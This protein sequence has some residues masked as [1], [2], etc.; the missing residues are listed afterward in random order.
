MTLLSCNV[1]DVPTWDT[2]PIQSLDPGML[3]LVMRIDGIR[4]VSTSLFFKLKYL[5][6][7]R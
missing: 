3:G 6:S 2:A 7:M 5:M 4:D 1:P